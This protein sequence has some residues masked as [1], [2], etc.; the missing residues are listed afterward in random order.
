MLTEDEIASTVRDLWTRHRDELPT[1]DRV[2]GYVTGRMGVPEVPEGAGDELV[3][4]AKMSVKNVLAPVRDAFAEALSVV[5][6]RASKDTDNAAAWAL[7]Q[8][9]KLDARQ[10]EAHRTATTYGTAYAIILK[11]GIRLR[12]PRQVFAVYADA[13]VDEWP[14]YALETWVDRSE[15]RAVRRGRL[16]DDEYVYEVNLGTV[17]KEQANGEG[18]SALQRRFTVAVEGEGEPHGFDFVPVARFVNSRDTEDMVVGE[19]EP[20]IGRQRAINAVNFDR[21]TVSRYGAFPQKYAIGWAPQTP[22]EL[23]Q[24]SAQRLMAFDDDQVKVG[25]FPQASVEPYN[26]ILAEMVLDVATAAHIPPFGLSGSV[27]NLSAEAIA[28]LLQPYHAKL[29]SKQE[30]FGETWEQTLRAYAALHGVDV[31]EDAE[32]VW[33]EIEARSFAQVVDGITKLASVQV[34]IEVL[35]EDVPGWSQQRLI[36]ARE[37]LRRNAGRETLAL[38]RGTREPEPVAEE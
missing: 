31:P 3:D 6:F 16:F 12:S 27:A 32:M 7:W 13:H 11:D 14:A 17:A 9:Q 26:S 8:G 15:K 28:L 23:V 21:L 35:L 25:A 20:L 22:S 18:V 34:P 30:S 36:A 33:A 5:G 1:H 38:L 24:A 2:Y 4:I 19:V 37:A 10:S 29:R